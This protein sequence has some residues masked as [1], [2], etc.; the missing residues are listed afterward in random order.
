MILVVIAEQTPLMIE[1]DE[2]R[3]RYLRQRLAHAG[4]ECPQI[5]AALEGSQDLYFDRISQIRMNRWTRGRV[6]LVGDAAYCVSLLAGQG[7]ALA[8]IGAY[9]LAAELARSASHIEAFDAYE[10]LLRPFMR[11]KQ[12]SAVRFAGSFAPRTALGVFLR[13][14]VVKAFVFP[15]VARFAIGDSLA[16]RI[17]LPPQPA[18]ASA[19]IVTDRLRLAP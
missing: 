11:E 17:T 9:T 18:E 8:L 15:G 16:D 14:L 5:V 3:K 13:N 19:E 4:W 10:R 7:A 1:S 12:D 2:D 6:A